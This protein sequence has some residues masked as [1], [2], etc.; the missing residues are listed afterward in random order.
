[1]LHYATSK[2]K[3]KI[4]PTNVKK[5]QKNWKNGTKNSIKGGNLSNKIPTGIQNPRQAIF[6]AHFVFMLKELRNIKK[7][8]MQVW[9]QGNILENKTLVHSN[10]ARRDYLNSRRIPECDVLLTNHGAEAGDPF[11]ASDHVAR[12]TG[13]HE[14]SIL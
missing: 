8:E 5:G 3:R 2:V 10:G 6:K 4:L 13:I 1:M 12:T 7:I 9:D 14:P 11:F